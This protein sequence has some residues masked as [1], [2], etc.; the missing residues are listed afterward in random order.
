MIWIIRFFLCI[1]FTILFMA[2]LFCA[3]GLGLVPTKGEARCLAVL[4]HIWEWAKDIH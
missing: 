3:W 1:V 2:L 4:E